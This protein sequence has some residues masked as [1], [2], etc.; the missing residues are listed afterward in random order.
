MLPNRKTQK[1]VASPWL[2][3]W[4]YTQ[5]EPRWTHLSPGTSLLT[6]F[7]GQLV[8][9]RTHFILTKRRKWPQWKY[10]LCASFSEFRNG[11]FAC[12]NRHEAE[13]K[14][15][16]IVHHRA[17]RWMEPVLWAFSLLVDLVFKHCFFYPG[18]HFLNISLQ[19]A[20]EM[21]KFRRL[22]LGRH[23]TCDSWPSEVRMRDVLK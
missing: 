20:S 12:E 4:K 16:H 6:E 10:C 15:G 5:A 14:V 18:P 19:A 21:L 3:F 8:G 13:R 11:A 22:N 17:Y 9:F 2:L 23:L 1:H 7:W